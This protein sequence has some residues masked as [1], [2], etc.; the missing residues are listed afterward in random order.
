[1]AGRVKLNMKGGRRM[2]LNCQQCSK[3]FVLGKG[4]RERVC[5]V[6]TRE[7]QAACLRITEFL[8]LRPDADPE[9]IATKT[10][11]PVELV[12]KMMLQGRLG[13]TMTGPTACS[14]CS[15]KL[16]AEDPISLSNGKTFC[17][18]CSKLISNQL[19]PSLTAPNAN[20]AIPNPS[21]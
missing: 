4:T 10:R 21:H 12:L 16:N 9:Q 18:A 7:E 15:R 19:R 1:M 17:A 13:N 20:L 6:C 5:P 3:P 2:L 11:I 8:M 14:R